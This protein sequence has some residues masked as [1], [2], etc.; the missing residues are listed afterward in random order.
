LFTLDPAQP[1]VLLALDA[2][3]A[4]AAALGDLLD[5]DSRLSLPEQ[6]DLL[7]WL[8]GQDAF[9]ED[10]D[11]NALEARGWL[12]ADVLHSRPAA[13]NYGARPGTGYSPENPDIRLFFGS[14][15]GF[16]HSLRNTLP[17]AAG[18]ESG[19]EDW[20]FIPPVLLARQARLATAGA[21]RAP[22]Q[23]YGMDGEPVVF[24]RDL[25]H[26]GNIETDEGDSV[27]VFIGQRRGGSALFAFDVSNP[28]QPRFM[29]TRSNAS[30]GFEQLGLTFSTPRVSLLD[31][32]AAAPT[33]VL[34][35][36]GGYHGGWENAR[37]VGKDAGSV[38][39]PLGNGVYV[40]D[41]AT[42]ALIWRAVGPGAA[43]AP[44]TG[45][46]A[47][48]VPG[49]V[50]SIPSAV[51]VIDGDRNGVD[52]RAYVGDSGGTVW[53]IDLTEYRHRQPG[54]SVTDARNWRVTALAA[55][56]GAG[57]DDRRFFH[58]PDVVQSR[59]EAG[60]YDG[61]VILSG[62]RAAP[63]QKTVR[64]FAYLLKDR[65]AAAALPAGSGDTAAAVLA[66]AALADIGATCNTSAAPA[67][68][69]LDLA[70]GWRLELTAPGEKGLSTP[71]V[72][73][74]VI[75]FTS[76]VPPVQTNGTACDATTG[77]GRVYAV[78]LANGAP[79]LSQLT[80]GGI[81]VA[82]DA[83]RFRP[84][85]PGLHGDIVP[86]RG[87]GGA[88]SP[89]PGAGDGSSGRDSSAEVL[90]PGAGSDGT[91]LFHIPGRTRW[92]AYWREEEVDGF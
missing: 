3:P 26:D 18:V 11:G 73:N 35:F 12:L 82:T 86:Y 48:A 75:V 49:L 76:Y 72:S 62:N 40:V 83:A 92:R 4:T 36:G 43:T 31:L 78:R 22:P 37:R 23:L 84:I 5:P 56:G 50:H 42:G 38:Q 87:G 66:H 9:D 34:V 44:V 41:A 28:D 60:N 19:R 51:T 68:T 2:L 88:A 17:G 15:D 52:D 67:C 79:A 69:A 54:T 13:V 61:V 33:P 90:V 55:L 77:S 85:G 47:L 65:P 91:R 58:A 29:W 16:F 46:G 64:N 27:W 6:L 81:R 7:G 32:G 24:L 70:A 20:A 57:V 39:D 71:L 21:G 59:D 80:A 25:D 45:P 53:R 74:G 1:G 14:N 8:R 30:P 10:G 89:A 63:R